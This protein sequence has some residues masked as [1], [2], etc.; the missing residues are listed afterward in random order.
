[1]LVSYQ[2]FQLL[3]LSPPTRRI[4]WRVGSRVARAG[5]G[6]DEDSAAVEAGGDLDLAAELVDDRAE[7]FE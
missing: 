6:V 1:M 7:G 3:L 2:P 5:S 4:A